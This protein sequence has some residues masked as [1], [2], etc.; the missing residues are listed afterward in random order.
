MKKWNKADI[1]SLDIE[2]THGGSG[3]YVNEKVDKVHG[4]KNEGLLDDPSSHVHVFS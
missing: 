2:M 3:V 4:S 1:E